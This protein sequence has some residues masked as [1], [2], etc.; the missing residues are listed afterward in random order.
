[1]SEASAADRLARDRYQR[2]V[3]RLLTV[4][5]TERRVR[6]AE[7]AFMATQVD[8]WNTRIDLFLALGGDWSEPEQLKTAEAAESA[9]IENEVS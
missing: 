8:V 1:M 9:T 2:G 7:E 4:L 3:E 6:A 5:E